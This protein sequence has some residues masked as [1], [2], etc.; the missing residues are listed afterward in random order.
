MKG[1]AD[2]LRYPV[3]PLCPLLLLI[4]GEICSSS[5]SSKIQ[6]NY[7]KVIVRRGVPCRN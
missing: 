4:V 1:S 6:A 5:L 3:H 7:L 2:N